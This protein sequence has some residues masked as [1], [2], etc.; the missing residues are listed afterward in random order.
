MLVTFGD[1]HDP[2]SV[3]TVDPADLAKSFGEGITL[4]RITVQITDEPVSKS[5]EKRL[6]LLKDQRGQLEPPR[7]CRRLQLLRRRSR[8]EQDNEQVFT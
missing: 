3:V 6:R 2:K 5:I 8:Y 1:L 7:D 4:K